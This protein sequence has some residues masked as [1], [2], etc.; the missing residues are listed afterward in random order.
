[1]GLKII[2][3]KLYSL[4]YCVCVHICM[5]TLTKINKKSYCTKTWIHSQINEK[6]CTHISL[7]MD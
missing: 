2:K 5:G 4:L 3:Y 1:M 6:E 7:N